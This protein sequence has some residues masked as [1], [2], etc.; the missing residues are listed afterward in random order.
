MTDTTPKTERALVAREERLQQHIAKQRAA[1]SAAGVPFERKE[2][3]LIDMAFAAGVDYIL[4]WL[5]DGREEA[6]NGSY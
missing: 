2:E 4:W 3:L 6:G 5:S 1:Y